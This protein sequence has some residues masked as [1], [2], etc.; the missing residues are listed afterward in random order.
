MPQAGL[1]R[2]QMTLQVKWLN[3]CRMAVMFI[4][5]EHG[6]GCSYQRSTEDRPWMEGG[7]AHLGVSRGGLQDTKCLICPG[8]LVVEL[9]LIPARTCALICISAK[10]TGVW[11]LSIL[12]AECIWNYSEFVFSSFLPGPVLPLSPGPCLQA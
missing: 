5:S 7:S 1:S 4:A 10:G 8:L 3:I 12:I 11:A 9:G 6:S 2:D